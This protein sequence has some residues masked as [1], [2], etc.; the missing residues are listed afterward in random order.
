MIY[1]FNNKPWD[2]N[3]KFPNSPKWKDDKSGDHEDDSKYD[4]YVVARFSPAGVV[5]HFGRLLGQTEMGHYVCDSSTESTTR[6]Q[7]FTPALITLTTY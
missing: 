6:R 3:R 5:K 2:Q 1:R 4:E 7:C